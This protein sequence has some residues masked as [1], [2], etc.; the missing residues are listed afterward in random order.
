MKFS[1]IVT[2][3]LALCMVIG[4]VV[5]AGAAK[6]EARIGHLE[7]PLQPRHQGL[8][9]VAKLVKERT[10]GEVEFKLFPS[11]QL[12]NQRQMNEGV[13]FG[14]IE[15]TVS[16]AAFL[17]GFNPAVSIMD[18]PF[19]LPADRAK[20][21]QLRQGA[22]GKALLKSFDS[23]GFKA[24]AAWPNGRKNFT[25]NK[26][27]TTLADYKGQSF[28]VMDSKILIEQFAAIGASAIA[29][30]FGELY[31]ALQN[32][33]VDGEENPLD[34]IQRMKFYEVQKYLVLSEHGAMED[35]ILFNPMFWD[36]LPAKYQKVIVDT[37]MEVMPSVEANKEQAQKDAL[38]V[39]E[40]A[41]TKVSPLSDE[42]RAAMRKLMYP[43]TTAA[44]LERAGAEGQAL[45]KLYEAEYN[46]IVK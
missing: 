7:S 33:V 8:E 44:Y 10:G 23:R 14:T 30:P 46:K 12:G 45:I 21:Q 18:I 29:L 43:K 20:A 36:S 37:F 3:A 42:D 24:I 19:I 35:F 17:G 41:G 2:I 5:S 9:K 34:T 11:S 25:S 6:Y 15:G 38:V 13:Q 16:P 1:R 4:G 22:F 28:R 31:T 39:I 32:G 27:L 40:K 26:P